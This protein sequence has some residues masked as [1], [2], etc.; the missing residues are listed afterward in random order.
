MS[1]F[2]EVS[3]PCQKSLIPRVTRRIHTAPETQPALFKG[4]EANDRMFAIQHKNGAKPMFIHQT[5][6]NEWTFVLETETGR[7]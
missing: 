1:L 7:K 2:D 5:R 4:I 3:G 6:G